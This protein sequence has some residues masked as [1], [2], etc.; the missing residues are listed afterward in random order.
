MGYRW[1]ADTIFTQRI[2]PVEP[3]TCDLCPRRLQICDHRF[4]RIPTLHG[5]L[6]IVCKLAPCPAPFCPGAR[7]TLSPL[8]EAQ[9]TWPPG[10]IGG[11]VLC[12]LGHRRFARPWSIPQL[13]LALRD[14]YRIALSEDALADCLQRYPLMVAA[15]QQDATALAQAYRD[16]DTLILTIDGLQPE[17]GHETL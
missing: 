14:S 12:W 11:D 7:R 2:L 3:E 5:P 16:L 15:R 13:R 4:H 17:K 8:A 1:P 6:E 10:T 9:L